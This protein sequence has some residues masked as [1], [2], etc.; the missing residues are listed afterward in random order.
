MLSHRF[1][2]VRRLTAEHLYIRLLENPDIVGDAGDDVAAQDLLLNHP[3]DGELD[4]A[5]VREMGNDVAM[6]LGLTLTS[7]S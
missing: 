1:P 4:D 5:T 2:R 7:S 3:W 6:K